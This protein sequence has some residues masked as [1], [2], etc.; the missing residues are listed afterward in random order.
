MFAVYDAVAGYRS[1]C[2]SV[3]LFAVVIV[4]LRPLGTQLQQRRLVLHVGVAAVS[5]FI[6]DVSL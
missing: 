6:P 3:C 1:V 2:L 4:R 5:V